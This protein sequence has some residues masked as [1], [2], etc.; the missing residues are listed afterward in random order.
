MADRL[1]VLSFV[2]SIISLG[3]T[4]AGV[5]ISMTDVKRRQLGFG[6]AGVGLLMTLG[7]LVALA[8]MEGLFAF[9]DA[10]MPL[11]GGMMWGALLACSVVAPVIGVLRSRWAANETQKRHRLHAAI[12]IIETYQ[13]A[14]SASS[15][16]TERNMAIGSLCKLWQALHSYLDSEQRKH[17]HPL[18]KSCMEIATACVD[19]T[20]E[21]EAPVRAIA[22][23]FNLES[24]SFTPPSPP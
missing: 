16:V 24:I 9:L 13:R 6:I 5:G 2:L 8:R 10:P 17:Y 23:H 7:G 18:A 11:W 14:T 1:S 22:R 20:D 15:S 12:A 4:I 19:G 3:V 21:F